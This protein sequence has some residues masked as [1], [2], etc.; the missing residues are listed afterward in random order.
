[1]V[2][3][4][5]SRSLSKSSMSVRDGMSRDGALFRKRNDKTKRSRQSLSKKSMRMRS[6]CCAGAPGTPDALEAVGGRYLA[7]KLWGAGADQSGAVIEINGTKSQFDSGLK[8]YA[9]RGRKGKVISN[10]NNH[11]ERHARL[12]MHQQL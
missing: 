3:L 6:V 10:S 9:T 5:Q 1:M 2:I 7:T 11:G 12:P 4:R 8:Q